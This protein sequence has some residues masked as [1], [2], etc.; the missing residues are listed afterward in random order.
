[1]NL[2]YH[3]VKQTKRVPW[4]LKL[5]WLIFLSAL[6]LESQPDIRNGFIYLRFLHQVPDFDTVYMEMMIIKKLKANL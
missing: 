4:I 6:S 3:L 1:M 5:H 2:Y